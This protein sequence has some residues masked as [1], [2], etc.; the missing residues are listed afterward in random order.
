MLDRHTRKRLLEI[1]RRAGYRS[2]C[3]SLPRVSRGMALC[4]SICH[5]LQ[6][7]ILLLSYCALA[8]RFASPLLS[9]ADLLLAFVLLSRPRRLPSDCS[10][11]LQC[12]D[13]A[14]RHRQAVQDARDEFAE[15]V[16]SYLCQIESSFY[17]TRQTH[18]FTRTSPS[19]R[20]N[21]GHS[22]C[23]LAP[24][25]GSPYIAT[26]LISGRHLRHPAER[27]RERLFACLRI[28]ALDA[29]RDVTTGALALS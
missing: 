10:S 12:Y 24:V 14:I 20:S 4:L 1:R 25:I 19:D 17:C 3:Q 22:A 8:L 6:H 5:R 2:T 21:H 9:I 23:V 7:A 13:S 18:L 26:E 27:L 15:E 29:Q 28:D 11:W 16:Y